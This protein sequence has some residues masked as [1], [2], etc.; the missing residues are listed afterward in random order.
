MG[1][2]PR[3]DEL[4]GVASFSPRLSKPEKE[5]AEERAGLTKRKE[6]KER[7]DFGEF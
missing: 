1:Q 7:K 4:V 6:E 3:G 5:T 2:G